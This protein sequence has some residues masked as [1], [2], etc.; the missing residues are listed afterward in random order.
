MEERAPFVVMIYNSKGI[1]VWYGL[2][3]DRSCDRLGTVS[4]GQNEFVRFDR[5]ISMKWIESEK[6]KTMSDTKKWILL[7][8]G[9]VCVVAMIVTAILVPSVEK[10]KMKQPVKVADNSVSANGLPYPQPLSYGM[11]VDMPAGYDFYEDEIVQTASK[12][13]TTQISTIYEKKASK[14][15]AEFMSLK[16]AFDLAGLPDVVYLE[17]MKYHGQIYK[18]NR[19]ISPV[20]EKDI[21]YDKDSRYFMLTSKEEKTNL[22]YVGQEK[23]RRPDGV[24]AVFEEADGNLS[25]LFAGSFEEGSRTGN[26]IE[27]SGYGPFLFIKR[28]ASYEKG[29]EKGRVYEFSV[30]E[31]ENMKNMYKAVEELIE[32]YENT[33]ALFGYIE[34]N[35]STAST[36][37]IVLKWLVR[38]IYTIYLDVPV[39]KCNLTFDGKMKKGERV[40]RGSIFDLFG[41][42]AFKGRVKG[43]NIEDNASEYPSYAKKDYLDFYL[44]KAGSAEDAKY[45]ANKGLTEAEIQAIWNDYAARDTTPGSISGNTTHYIELPQIQMGEENQRP[46]FNDNLY[47]N[48]PN[49]TID[50]NPYANRVPYIPPS[51]TQQTPDYI[52]PDTN[53]SNDKEVTEDGGTTSVIDI[54]AE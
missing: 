14:Q 42:L 24:G 46:Q 38:D 28:I 23:N 26:G 25:L 10:P 3:F 19:D 4:I 9:C 11:L 36:E 31:R 48:Y 53:E 13:Y 50:R 18:D 32:G 27:F 17:V 52:V 29:H 54:G 40:G 49:I 12:Y 20:I 6:G 43:K 30:A 51:Q 16:E 21:V 45:Y 22:Y 2:H 35:F 33:G 8:I 44:A 7:V 39:Y 34:S 5:R 47:N 37:A 41:N 15:T 1:F